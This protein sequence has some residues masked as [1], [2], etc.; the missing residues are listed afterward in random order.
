[1]ICRAADFERALFVTIATLV[2]D[3][4]NAIARAEE[5][6]RVYGAV[7]RDAAQRAMRFYHVRKASDG[8]APTIA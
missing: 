7:P 1:M 4:P 2:D 3:A 5:F 8:A 6:G